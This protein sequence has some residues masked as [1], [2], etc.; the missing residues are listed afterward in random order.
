MARPVKQ[1]V[2]YFPHDADASEGRTLSIL[3]NNFGHEGVSCWWQ[4]LER[5]SK[6]NNHVIAIRNGEDTEFMAAKFHFK[7]ERLI[8]ILNKMAELEAI[9]SELWQKKT[10]WVQNLVDRLRDV[11][12]K[13]HQALPT[14]PGLSPTKT[15]LS[16]PIT[17]LLLPE[18]PQSKLN[19]SKL[20]NSRKQTAATSFESYKE[21]LRGKY[22]ELNLDEEWEKCQIWHQ[23]H[24]KQ[25]KSPSLTL[26]NWM[27][28]ARDIKV[29]AKTK[30][31]GSNWG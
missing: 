28:K 29:K 19:K 10:I 26:G 20:N 24:S 15:R 30:T 14:K 21:K 23:D 1:T 31:N 16:P 7:P 4:L 25:I 3:F 27:E 13:R 12:S 6:T 8:E 5:V 17:E 11:Y 2:D 18:N 22:P 9:D